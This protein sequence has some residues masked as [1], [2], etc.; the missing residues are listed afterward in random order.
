MVHY[1]AVILV[2][3]SHDTDYYHK[4]RSVWKKY[5]NLFPSIKVYMLYGA[6]TLPDQDESD[7]VYEDISETYIPGILK[8]TIR[9]MKHVHNTCTYDYLIRTN[10]STLWD[11]RNIEQLL[12]SCPTTRCYAGGHNLHPLTIYSG[13]S[14]ILNLNNVN[15]YSGVSIILTPDLVEEFI[16]QTYDYIINLSDDTT[17]FPIIMK[18]PDDIVI[19]IFMDTTPH[20]QKTTT[21]HQYIEDCGPYDTELINNKIQEGLDNKVAYFRVKNN[22]TRTI[23]DSIIYDILLKRIYNL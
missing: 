16:N 3:A 5:M 21:L 2:I 20:V 4:A 15:I 17:N 22:D 8:K 14:I 6:T 23:T 11:L 19:G 7:L 13:E 1:R 18:L 10:I 9:A 12:L